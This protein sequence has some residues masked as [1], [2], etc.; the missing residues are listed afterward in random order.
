MRF[1]LL[2]LLIIFFG[3]LLAIPVKADTSTR[4]CETNTMKNGEYCNWAEGKS[5]NTSNTTVCAVESTT[6]CPANPSNGTYNFSCNVN[7][8]VLSCNSGY[9]NCSGTCTAIGSAPNCTN[10]NTCSGTCTTCA[11]G[12]TLSGGTCSA[13]TLKLGSTSVGQSS[14]LQAGADA[15]AYISGNK[16]GIGNSNPSANLHINA[17]TDTE[18]LRI[19]TSNY[20]PFII[21]NAA[22]TA[23]LFRIDQDGNITSLGE[24]TGSNNYWKLNGSD[25]YASSTSWNLGIGTTDPGAKLQISGGS[26]D[27]NETTPGTTK[28]S[29]HLDPNNSATHFG[30]AITFASSDNSN[31][32]AGIYVRGDGGYGTKMYLATTDSYATGAR[33]RMMIDYNGNVGIAA[34]SPSQKL[35]IGGNVLIN[36]GNMMYFRDTSTYI[37]EGSGLNIVAGNT[38]SL[39]L[40]GGTGTDM[41]ISSSGNVGIGITNP[42]SKLDVVGAINSN[43]TVNGISLC[44]AGDCKASWDEAGGNAWQLDGNTVGQDSSLGTSDNYSLIF[45]TNNAERARITNSGN[46]ALGTATTGTRLHVESP[47][48]AV[49]FFKSTLNGGSYS[50]YIGNG[51]TFTGEEFG[52]YYA[53][54]DTRLATYDLTNNLSIY[55]GHLSTDP[56][57]VINASGNVGV[58]TTN[59]TA[60][61]EVNGTFKVTG[62]LNSVVLDRLSG[63]GNRIVMADASGSLYATSSAA[64]TGLPDGS[65]GQTLRHNG[66]S[67]VANSVLFNNG[68]NVG[69]GLTSPSQKLTV[70]GNIL[71]SGGTVSAVNFHD[72]NGIYNVNL[73]GGN[74]RGLAAGYSGGSYGGIGYN[75]RHTTTSAQYIAPGAD[76][77]SY[78]LFT[79]GGFRFYGAPVG[80]AG[81]TVSLSELMYISPAGNVG[82]GITPSYKLHV[83]GTALFTQPVTVGAPTADAHAATKSYVDATIPTMIPD[84]LWSGTLNGNIWNGNSGVGNVGVGTT[85]PAGKLEIKQAMSD[86][87]N[88]FTAP[89]LK[90]GTTN[91]VDNTGFVGIT[92]D[93]STSPNYGWS[94]GA[95]RSTNGIADF[96]WKN[97]QNSA[98]GNELLRITSTGSVGIGTT[99]PTQ[100]LDINGSVRIAT[101]NILYLGAARL[102]ESTDLY[103]RSGSSIINYQGSGGG[104]GYHNFNNGQ[105]YINSSGNV[106]VGLTNPAVK[107]DVAGGMNLTDRQYTLSGNVRTFENVAQYYN[108]S[109]P[110]TGTI[111][112]TIAN[113]PNIM[114]EAEIVIQGYQGLTTCRVRGYTYT[115][116]TT[117]HM[118]AATCLGSG[119][120]GKYTV[121][122]AKRISDNAR[123]ILIG[124]TSSNWGN[125]IHAAVTRV[126]FGYPGSG[127][128]IGN[129]SIAVIT[130]ESPYTSITDVDENI[131]FSATNP[132]F[133]GNVG[134]GITNPGTRL[135]VVGSGSYSIDASNYRIG[136]VATPTANTDAANK[137][138]VDSAIPTIPAQLWSGTLNGNIWNGSAGAG[139]V[140]VGTNSPSAKLDIAGDVNLANY[141]VTTAGSVNRGYYVYKSGTTAYGM[142]LQYTNGEYGTMIFASNQA[143]RFVGF[144][145]VGTAL[146]D[147]DMI[148]YMRVD[149]DYGNV[150][151][152][153][154][155]PGSKLHVV[156]NANITSTL[157]MGGDI[158][159]A[160]NN[161]TAINKLTVNTIDPLY[162]IKGVNYS[163]F[164]PSMV[165]GVKEEYVGLV[166]IDQRLKTGEYEK[167]IDFNQ[168]AEGSDLWV[169]HKT[170]DFSP[171]KVQVIITPIAQFANTYYFIEDDKLVLRADKEV[172][173]SYRLTGNRHDWQE[174][175]TRALD[176]TEKAGFIID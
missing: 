13:A 158:N 141:A 101:G 56:G 42:T 32:Q 6:P 147:D 79:G 33:T 31:A 19:I 173:V 132:I 18:G 28:G 104:A 166:K 130:D 11:P 49:A 83:N 65:S 81:R 162:N 89:H 74:G 100:K 94:I 4:G 117:W 73:G 40:A 145:K 21:R 142:K 146:E 143:N 152:G 154:T 134:I 29:L 139:N 153:T 109:T 156:G 128:S 161:I 37:N 102:Y 138:Y 59:P 116:S 30:N 131:G 175:P 164:A 167:I 78:L 92:F 121:R 44:I 105:F 119:T 93:A 151:I 10:Y 68:T 176:Q 99:S 82:I 150:G 63:T 24:I 57:I 86:Y 106:G 95:V 54:N 5:W 41:T 170:I 85:A 120:D 111:A 113:T 108:G 20:S 159:M 133:F 9:V 123:V 90:L 48:G 96:V 118:P 67:W 66:T 149:L 160:N 46:L 125:Y 80:T 124:N 91:T 27:W 168:V 12:Y 25:L 72:A 87:T 107:L 64:A 77:V 97:H 135:T 112:V 136:G 36:S 122:F 76:T 45:K 34:N 7:S 23:D 17:S 114:L 127:D 58:N 61:L 39:N 62:S 148:E 16:M 38:R 126:T 50:G 52:L 70:N 88:S 53:L 8:C 14:L 1:K 163:T 75:I 140:G 169:W 15:L 110:T 98:T 103:I 171:D 69:I 165:G 51:Q 174:W 43:S 172:E 47:A 157:T 115:G 71:A 155:N 129:W 2:S 35:T 60:K 3:L 84:Q 137:A 144:G 22:D 26:A 55:G